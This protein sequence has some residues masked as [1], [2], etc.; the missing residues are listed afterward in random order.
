MYLQQKNISIL[1]VLDGVM[2]DV[3]KYSYHILETMD[4]SLITILHTYPYQLD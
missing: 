2:S 3:S 1:S 4:M